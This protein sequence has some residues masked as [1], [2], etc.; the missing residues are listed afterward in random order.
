MC[1]VSVRLG[2]NDLALKLYIAVAVLDWCGGFSCGSLPRHSVNFLLGTE[3]PDDPEVR[4]DCSYCFLL[5]NYGQKNTLCEAFASKSLTEDSFGIISSR[6]TVLPERKQPRCDVQ[7]DHHRC[8][9]RRPRL[10]HRMSSLWPGSHRPGASLQ[11]HSGM[12]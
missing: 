3:I 1:D 5:R 8:W 2:S 7:C 11:D 9:P 4:V 12:Q 6:E 10:R